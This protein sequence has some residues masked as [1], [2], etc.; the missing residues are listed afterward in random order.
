MAV[1]NLKEI[2]PDII[3]TCIGYGDEE[4]KLKKLVIEL[5]VE[6]QVTFLKDIP[7]GKKFKGLRMLPKEVRNKMKYKKDGGKI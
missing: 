3:Y 2:Y 4:E 1:R 7:S 5:K 6:D